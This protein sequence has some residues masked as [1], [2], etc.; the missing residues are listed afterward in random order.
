MDTLDLRL[1]DAEIADADMSQESDSIKMDAANAIVGMSINDALWRLNR[2][3]ALVVTL[4][5]GTTLKSPDVAEF[6]R[7]RGLTHAVA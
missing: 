7:S 3:G 6:L 1:A 2:D 4:Q 5:S